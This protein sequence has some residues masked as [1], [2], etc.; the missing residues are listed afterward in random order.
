MTYIGNRATDAAT[1]GTTGADAS[2]CS[3][4][5]YLQRKYQFAVRFGLFGSDRY[6]I[7]EIFGRQASFIDDRI[8]RLQPVVGP[9]N[10]IARLVLEIDDVEQLFHI[11]RGFAAGSARIQRFGR[12]RR[13]ALHT[14]HTAAAGG[15]AVFRRSVDRLEKVLQILKGLFD[16]DDVRDFLL[17]DGRRLGG[18]LCGR[19][20][21]TADEQPYK[22]ASSD[23]YFMFFISN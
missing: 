13:H 7:P 6:G 2:E 8:D 15:G 23:K 5:D 1:S 22:I 16:G 20:T 11:G 18:F 10:S 21:G 19:V 12:N 3:L 9:Q 17:G 4:S 14:P